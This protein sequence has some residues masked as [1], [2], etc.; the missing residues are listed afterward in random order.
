MVASSHGRG[1]APLMRAVKLEGVVG[2]VQVYE[3]WQSG[4]RIV[5]MKS[6]VRK[7]TDR[8]RAW[9]P[10]V[11]LVHVCHNDIAFH[12]RFNPKPIWPKRS[13]DKLWDFGLELKKNFPA[14]VI[15]L[16]APWPRCVD[17]HSCETFIWH[18]NTVA[19]HMLSYM[20]CRARKTIVTGGPVIRVLSSPELWIS[21]R[22][23]TADGQ[24]FDLDNDDGLHLNSK[25]KTMLARK[26][27]V[28]AIN[29]EMITLP[30]CPG[31]KVPKKPK[32]KVNRKRGGRKQKKSMKN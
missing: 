31:P 23:A 17:S 11:C 22:K 8:I 7:D 4:G 28:S 6:K 1:M 5:Q 14:A 20:R 16:S 19:N 21:A 9:D 29:H 24:Y 30:P 12:A 2:G 15:I 32:R 27:V 18:Y 13:I 10:E 3:C 25:G 26:W